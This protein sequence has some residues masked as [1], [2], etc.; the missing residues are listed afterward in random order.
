MSD[1]R[2]LPLAFIHGE[3][4]LE[5]P[6]DLFI[7]PDAL[8]VILDAFEGP[9]DLLLYLIKKHK[10]DVLDMPIV[11]I[12]EQY[13]QYVE[14]MQELK[15]ALAA[16]Y[17]VMAA[18]LAHIKSRLLLPKHEELEEDEEDPRAEL[19]RKL[20]EYE[21]FKKAAEQMDLMPRLERDTFIAEAEL[22]S[23]VDSGAS[24]ESPI[25]LQELLLAIGDV[26]ARAKKYEHHHIAR[27]VL[28]TRE[29]M[30]R[31]LALLKGGK[32]TPF[33]TLFDESE[34]RQGV[35]VSFL[36]V[37]ELCKEGVIDIDVVSEVAQNTSIYVKLMQS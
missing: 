3:A 12:T 32:A 29:R 20:K 16:D 25:M 17:L 34:G 5:K 1:A 24:T 6:E 31:I 8:E 4:V 21:Q 18:T 33:Y 27:E 26:I 10:I 37:L 11:R 15:L 14:M 22:P 7:P 30:Q 2:Q 19:I 36:A 9:L 35:V 13:M 23:N 28:S